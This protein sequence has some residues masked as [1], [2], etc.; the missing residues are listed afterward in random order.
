MNE[1]EKK[2]AK[3]VAS[4]VIA[5]LVAEVTQHTINKM[6]ENARIPKIHHYQLGTTALSAGALNMEKKL[7]PYAI[8]GGTG[9]IVHDIVDVFRDVSKAYTPLPHP[10][11]KYELDSDS[12]EVHNY[13]IS[14][15]SLK[16]RYNKIAEILQHWT[17]EQA[18][19][20]KVMEWS[21]NIV[22]NDNDVQDARDPVQCGK[23]LAYW[24][25]GYPDRKRG[26]KYVKDPR[27]RS[28]DSFQTA[29]RTLKWRTGDC[30]CLSL[31][32]GTGM[33]SLGHSNGYYLVS[34]N[35]LRP[36]QYSHIYPAIIDNDGTWIPCELT[37]S[38]PVGYQP[39]YFKRGKI[40]V[41]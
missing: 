3:G 22:V 1:N 23:A 35:P 6:R 20:P 17:L 19:D 4:G 33:H 5:F 13:K 7:A 34:Q 31:L 37:R 28:F 32:W 24:I 8:G 41:D 40:L 36:K 10:F 12:V 27:K 11:S 29:T 21:R 2:V 25:N 16:K 15:T 38:K 26:V 9:L 39:H 14:D 18:S 30:D